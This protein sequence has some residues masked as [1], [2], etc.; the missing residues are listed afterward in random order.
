MVNLTDKQVETLK[1]LYENDPDFRVFV[2]SRLEHRAKLAL[3]AA[4]QLSEE[5]KLFSGAPVKAKRKKAT[6][7][8]P[9]S[10]KHKDAVR[11]ALSKHP[12]GVNVNELLQCLTEAG[13]TITKATLR[14]VLHGLKKNF[15]SNLTDKIRVKTVG[16]KPDTRYILV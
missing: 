5:Q 4:N 13:H 9:G 2:V 16:S 3:E 6:N 14:T 12:K 1:T 7:S 10:K 11:D 8:Q 15:D